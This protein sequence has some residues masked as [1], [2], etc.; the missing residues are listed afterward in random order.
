MNSSIHA[1]SSDDGQL[2]WHKRD[3]DQTIVRIVYVDGVHLDKDRVSDLLVLDASGT[4]HGVSG[5]TG[6]T[7]WSSPTSLLSRET[8]G[9][10]QHINLI[11]VLEDSNVRV[12][13]VGVREHES[14]EITVIGIDPT[15]SGRQI[16]RA[17]HSLIGQSSAVIGRFVVASSFDGS[18]LSMVNLA[19]NEKLDAITTSPRHCQRASLSRVSGHENDASN[20]VQLRRTQCRSAGDDTLSEELLVYHL[21]TRELEAVLLPTSSTEFVAAT[22]HES[23]QL[24]VVVHSDMTVSL[25]DIDRA[26]PIKDTNTISK[27]PVTPGSRGPIET[28]RFQ[29]LSLLGEQF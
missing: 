5:A 8:V 21:K 7:L 11:T 29:P 13:V 19:T 22:T 25:V 6:T 14:I 3:F 18:T 28:V 15:L 24:L 20:L 26:T 27:L 10:L 16:F 1:W 12:F 2:L 4:V 23:K 9:E 17:T